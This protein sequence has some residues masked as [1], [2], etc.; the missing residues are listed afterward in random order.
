MN[1][2]SVVPL[3]SVIIPAY[4]SARFIR[5]CVDSVLAQTR[6]D[7]EVIVVDDGSTDE[8]RTILG[9]YGNRVQV[10]AGAHRGNAAARN[11]GWRAA[12]GLW[13]CFL[14]SDDRW[15]PD[16]LQR[17]LDDIARHPGTEVH[18][19]QA[20]WFNDDGPIR[21]LPAGPET[22]DGLWPQLARMQPFGSSLSG[23][24]VRRACLERVDGFDENLKL[25]VDWDMWIR[26]A[27]CSELR[28]CADP[29]VHVRL[30]EH[31]ANRNDAVRL[32][33]YLQ[34]LRKHR[35]LFVRRGMRHAWTASYGDRLMRLGRH[36]L[37][38]ERWA[39]AVAALWS[40]LRYGRIRT[41]P[42]KAK[43]L[44][45]GSLGMAGLVRERSV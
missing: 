10:L 20:T 16:K 41:I 15:A 43:L 11:R 37:K 17:Q 35:R 30:H 5:E 28:W 32:S 29:T 26:L 44:V 18:F 22:R 12:H 6:T 25:S 31:N 7:F 23:V 4:N 45:E 3:I 36:H 14:D 40:S 34:C 42:A 33:M 19:P 39:P 24:M 38:H 27:D 13:V 1:P 2:D 9:E 8:T 21:P